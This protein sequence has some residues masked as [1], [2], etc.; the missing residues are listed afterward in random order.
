MK[1]ILALMLALAMLLGCTALAEDAAPALTKDLVILFTSDAHC[2]ID[3]GFGYAGLA[4]VRDVLAAKNH[5]ILVDNGD[6]IQGEPVG[7]MTKGEAII[8]LMNT[9]GYEVAIPGNHEFDYGMDNFLGLVEKANYPYISANFT[10][11]GELVFQPYVI[12]EYDGVKVAFV[13]VTTPKTFTSSTPTYFQDENGNYVYGFSEDETGEKLYAAVQSAVDA[14]RA[15]GAT[16]VVA[17]AHLGN[18]D[19]CAP[20]RYDNVITNTNGIDVFLDGHSHDTDQVVVT[21]KDGVEVPRSACGTKLGGI[22]YAVISAKDGSVSTGV[23]TWD[24]KVSAPV[25]FG[26]ENDVSKAVAAATDTLNAKLSEVVAKTAVDLTIVDPVAV[27]ESGKPIRIIR[28]AETN[29]GDLCADAYRDQSGAEIAFVNGGGIRVSIAAGDITL[30]DILKVHPFGNAMCVVEATGQEILDA[31]EW[32]S[33]NVPGEN[34]GFLQVSG[35]TYEIHTYIESSCTSDDKGGFT[36][37]TGE[38]RVKNV[39]VGGEDLVLDKTYTLASHNYML[40]SGGDGINMF[41]DNTVLQDEVKLDNQVLIDYIVDTLGGVVGE[42]YAE[43]YGEGRIVAVA[44][45]PAE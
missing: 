35:L 20:W 22:G 27:D 34:G 33:R 1:K 23:Y 21:N 10:H 43:P 42:Q 3:S 5:V 24:N 14:A 30:N 39:K 17:M 15:E 25:L 41:T 19:T 16:Y 9:V 6:A 44:E 18:E 4:T 8:E 13:G 28:N 29:L 2:G 45:K 31:L 11:N 32:A 38:Y 37:V 36:G 26:I 7:T 12:K 40:K